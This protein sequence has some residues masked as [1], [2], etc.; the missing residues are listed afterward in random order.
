MVAETLN[1]D[2]L[3]IVFANAI[4]AIVIFWSGIM[5]AEARSDTA[6]VLLDLA[7]Q[8]AYGGTHQRHEM[9]FSGLL[10]PSGRVADP[11]ATLKRP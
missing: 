8:E 10:A 5:R 9:Q 2:K 4:T 1:E 3:A 7:S 6:D 11:F